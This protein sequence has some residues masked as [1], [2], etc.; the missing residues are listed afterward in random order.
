MSPILFKLKLNGHIRR[1]TFQELPNWSDLA[2]KL[3]ALYNIPLD[4]VAVSYIDNDNDEI[5]VSSDEELQDFYKSSYRLGDDIRLSVVNLTFPRD[6]SSPVNRNVVGKELFDTVESDWHPIPPFSLADLFVS[7]G[8][9]PEGP[10]AFVEIV[11]SDSFGAEK[12]AGDINSDGQSTALDK[13][14]GRES[15]FGAASVT[16]LVEEDSARKYPI[17]VL[18]IN[19]STRLG[20]ASMGP[21]DHAIPEAEPIPLHSTPNSRESHPQLSETEDP[22]LPT[23][24]GQSTSNPPNLYRDFASLLAS[25]NQ[26]I[27]SH[28][29]LSEGVRNIVNNATNGEY[30]RAHRAFLSETAQGISQASEAEVKRMEAETAQRI[31]NSLSNI[32]RFFLST[33]ISQTPQ[34]GDQNARASRLNDTSQTPA[35]TLNSGYQFL[36][37]WPRSSGASSWHVPPW[38]HGPPPHWSAFIPPPPP[39][40]HFPRPPLPPTP[41]VPPPPGFHVPPPPPPPILTSFRRHG[42]ENAPFQSMTPGDV[43][44]KE[45]SLFNVPQSAASPGSSPHGGV[46]GVFPSVDP[47]SS[48]AE[49]L[50]SQ[51]DQAKQAYKT[52]KESYRQERDRRREKDTI[53]QR[54]HSEKIR[55]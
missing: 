21:K 51:L 53:I 3:Q 18:D 4:F 52:A 32:C 38:V 7:K 16:S 27:T 33:N 30:W 39:P 31:Y 5:T 43:S 36:N 34:E 9:I 45:E 22:P 20:S 10:H 14:K 35:S 49:D 50:R 46:A 12:D 15:S 13:G 25:F 55:Q 6:N 48:T 41:P 37:H 26:I 19:S 29:E 44:R 1:I 42:Q 28:P 11:N 24:N 47:S 17:H 54:E 23:F 8:Q 40:P 2:L